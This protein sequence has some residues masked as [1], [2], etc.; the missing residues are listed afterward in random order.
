MESWPKSA[1]TD[2]CEQKEALSKYSIAAAILSDPVLNAIRHELKQISPD[3]RI[4][5]DQIRS[6]LEQEVL[7][8][9]VL[10]GDKAEEARRLIAKAANKER[11]NRVDKDF[12]EQNTTLIQKTPAATP[13]PI[14]P[15]TIPP[16]PSA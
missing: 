9:E 8:E 1:L 6:V 15:I 14:P 10:K 3:V 2:Y 7:I 16:Q 11:K 13:T 12:A 4:D 5:S